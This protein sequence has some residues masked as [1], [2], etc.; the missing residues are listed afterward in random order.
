MNRPINKLKKNLKRES[1]ITGIEIG[2][3][4]EKKNQVKQVTSL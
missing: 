1:M 4:A 3:I 2:N